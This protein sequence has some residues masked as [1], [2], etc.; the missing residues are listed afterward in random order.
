MA[1][2]ADVVQNCQVNFH[3]FADD[4]QIYLQCPLSRVCHL[5]PKTRRLYLWSGALDVGQSAQGTSWLHSDAALHHSSS[6]LMSWERVTKFDCSVSKL[7]R[8]LVSIC[9]SAYCQQDML[10]LASPAETSPSF[11]GHWVTEDT[12]SR[13]CHIACVT[14]SWP[15]RRRRWAATSTECR[16]TSDLLHQQV[17]PWSVSAASRRTALARRPQRVR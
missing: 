11:V 1:D 8:T 13:L 2:L 12:S 10:L 6:A 9:M 14:Q 5:R 4:S 3:S 16:S 7:R 17:R 15:R